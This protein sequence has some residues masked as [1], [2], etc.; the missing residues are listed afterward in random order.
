MRTGIKRVVMDSP[1]FTQIHDGS[2]NDIPQIAKIDN[3]SI[4]SGGYEDE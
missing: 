3:V 4:I 1:V 2:S